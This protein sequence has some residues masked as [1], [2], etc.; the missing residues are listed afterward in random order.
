MLIY[1]G[2]G[3]DIP[4]GSLNMK[5]LTSLLG[6]RMWRRDPCSF[7]M[8]TRYLERVVSHC[9]PSLHNSLPM[10]E[11]CGLVWLGGGGLSAP[12]F[13]VI[14]MA[15][16]DRVLVW[17]AQNILFG[18]CAQRFYKVLYTV[19]HSFSLTICHTK[20]VFIIWVVNISPDVIGPLLKISQKVAALNLL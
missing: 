3:L 15:C 1:V 11:A 4:G 16:L 5:S 20:S 8:G 7:N 17:G 13:L 14:Q 6:D 2:Q 10:L 19:Y 9:C 18:L 12:P